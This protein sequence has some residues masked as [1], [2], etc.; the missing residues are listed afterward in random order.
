M[1]ATVTEPAPRAPEPA[2]GLGAP[3]EDPGQESAA[4]SPSSHPATAADPNALPSSTRLVVLVA[5]W[6]VVMV[7]GLVLV[8][9]ALGPLFQERDQRGL[10]TRFRQQMDQAAKQSSG[11]AG[12]EV[13]TTA[14]SLG[15]PVAIVDI[16]AAGLRQVVVEGVGAGQTRQ[17]PGHV[18][19]TAGLGQ[20][21]NSALV[22]RS[23]TFGGSF[24]E[25][26]AL[27]EGDRILV[28]TVQGQSVYAVDQVRTTTIVPVTDG[29]GYSAPSLPAEGAEVDAE[30]GDAATVEDLFGPSQGDQL[31]LVSS[32]SVLPWNGS[33]AVVV[34]AHLEGQ[35]FEPT[36]QN[37]RTEGR[38]GQ[39]GDTG[40]WAPLV[41][42]LL[43]YA[44]AAAAAVVLYRRSLLTAWL[45]T[46]GP[47]IVFTI[48]V[49]EAT[50]RLLPAWW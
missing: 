5:A 41:L 18:P 37:G 2:A 50:S 16:G 19:G 48:L 32:D 46:T 30:L 33:Q 27:S 11:L 43:G 14:P 22:G 8:L 10:L 1:T 44:V 25:L 15:D 20:P 23:S 49:A 29:D 7:L 34:V 17:G 26:G 3:F 31:T 36:P 47:L 40:A 24:A 39:G 9:Y 28:S 35:P 21:G 12:V 45:L 38:T 42:A 6:L 13:P 4:A